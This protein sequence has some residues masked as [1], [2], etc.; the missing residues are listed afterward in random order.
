MSPSS[1]L[2]LV[3][4]LQRSGHLVPLYPLFTLAV[5]VSALLGGLLPGLMAVALS[6][7]FLYVGLGPHY[8]PVVGQQL[9]WM[10]LIV[11]TIIGVFVS[12][13]VGA[14]GR[15]QNTLRQSRDRYRLLFESIDEGFCIIA[16]LFDEKGKPSDWRFLEVNPAF[17]RHNGLEHATGKTIRELVPS[18]ETRWLDIYG[19]VA[20]TGAPIRF[21]E[22]SQAFNRWFDV[23]AFQV[24]E[25]GQ[26]R[27]AVLFNNITDRK[28]AEDTA[29]RLAAIVEF[30]DEAI[31]AKTLDGVI[32]SW[33]HGAQQLYG[34]S[35]EEV[36]GRQIS[37]LMPQD[38]SDEL[39][40]ILERL[41]NGES[42]EPFE[43]L[44]VRKDGT[45]IP[46]LLKVSPLKDVKGDIVGASSFAHDITE[47]KLAQDALIRSEKLAA[48]GRLA[49]TIA[50][51]VNN[52]LEAVMNAV[53]LACLDLTLTPETRH[54]LTIADQELRRAAHIT[55]QTLGFY[56]ETESP[57]SVDLP[58]LIEEVLAV[59]AR[60]LQ[61]RNI[62]V[63]SRYKCGLCKE[64]C[65][66]CFL[67]NAGELRQIISNLLV[68]GIDALPDNGSLY[69]RVSRV[70]NLT[71]SG[72]KV[73]L[74]IAD[75]GCGIRVENLKRIFEPFFTTKLAFGTGLGLWI[76]EELVRKHNGL[77]KVRSLKDKG[78]VFRIAFPAMPLVSAKPDLAA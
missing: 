69:V 64:A 67:V 3:W 54:N 52:P 51:E 14:L 65:A 31:I 21:V 7:F 30:S 66:E 34:Y 35:E 29:R 47:R 6:L 58:K 49:A 38:R 9:A 17:E 22:F 13:I 11:F 63:H 71:G 72:Q 20:V 39:P 41:R 62:T 25:P 37:I 73:Y 19:S 56:R 2:L 68:N 15:S 1:V 16:M 23:Y 74:T 75:N 48:A 57:K 8:L 33:N 76:T 36:L 40:D 18:I 24:G 45:V 61:N 4:A 44:R 46:V 78:T 5:I 26:H 70:T 42:I 77:I 32:T 53:Y 59:Y 55:Q 27:V 10:S 28:R 43:T 50:H 60:K 12:I